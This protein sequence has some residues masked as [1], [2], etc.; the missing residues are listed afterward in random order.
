MSTKSRKGEHLRICVREDVE[1]ILKTTGFEEVE[2]VHRALPELDLEE[3][4]TSTRFLGFELKA[5]VMILPMTGGH[6]ASARMNV[7]L[8]GVAQEMGLAFA[9]GSLRAAFEHPSMLKTYSV[10]RVAPDILLVANLGLPQLKR[11]G[12]GIARR[13]VE[14]IDAD[15][16]SIHL[17]TLQEAL[18]P[19]G[20]PLYA[21]GLAAISDLCRSAD[22]PVIVKETG[23]GIPGEVAAELER[24]GVSAVDVS[25]A[26]GTSWAAVEF[27]RSR[28]VA[29]LIFWDWGIPTAVCTADVRTRVKI[30]VIAS[31]GIRSGLD[32]AKAIALGADIV[33]LAL[34]LLRASTRG[35]KA[36]RDYLQNFIKE[37]RIAMFL[38]GARRPEDLRRSRVLVFGRTRE[39]FEALGI[40][41]GGQR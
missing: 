18:Q 8:A 5:P 40:A 22:F 35:R 11:G 29:S 34:P 39:W 31:G 4:D 14:M 1:G 37:L 20:E 26:G 12:S 13:A 32:A 23:G 6:P 41:V 9:V 19:E 15:A 33:G 3:V 27:F 10:R 24:A 21:G 2:L 30:P 28:S 7:M 17:N 16:I 36:V 38:T 25:G